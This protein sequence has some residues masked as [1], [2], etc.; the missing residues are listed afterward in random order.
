[1][2]AA[3]IDTPCMHVNKDPC[4][5]EGECGYYDNAKL[6]ML[7]LLLGG[8]PKLLSFIA[9]YSG[10]HI[11]SSQKPELASKPYDKDG[12]GREELTDVGRADSFQ[13]A[14]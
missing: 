5:V 8:I 3:A 4:G 12:G 7:F 14:L 1:M 9:F 13:N 6:A 11:L 2:W 10:S